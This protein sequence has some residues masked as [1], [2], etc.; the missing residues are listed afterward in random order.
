MVSCRMHIIADITAFV[1]QQFFP[2]K[3]FFLKSL[4]CP[5]RLQLN[6]S[7]EALITGKK[8]MVGI[9]LEIE[10]SLIFYFMM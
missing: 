9:S 5:L 3:N 1:E 6:E 7:L 10:K 4:N 8:E 2:G